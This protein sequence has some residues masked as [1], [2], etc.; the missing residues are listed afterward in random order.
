MEPKSPDDLRRSML[1]IRMVEQA[2]A[3]RYK[4]RFMRCPVH[5]S[6]GQEAVAVGVAAALRPNDRAFSSH[7]CHAH[8]LA[9]GGDLKAM[10]AELHGSPVGCNGGRGGSMHLQGGQL[11]ASLPIVGSA[12][13]PAV[14]MA[15]A[16]RMDGVDRVTVAFF[17]DAALEEGAWHEAA[18]LA[19][20]KSAPVLFVCENNDRSIY[21][22][23]ADRQPARDRGNLA[24]AHGMAW[25]EVNGTN[26][27]AVFAKASMAV[28]MAK[29]GPVLLFADCY[30]WAEHCG[31]AERPDPSSWITRDPLAR[32]EPAPA[33]VEQI[34]EE[35]AAAFAEVAH[36]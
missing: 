6:I 15:M 16:D 17:G 23:L 10:I 11:V 32:Y 20:V 2:I 36:A 21:T 33:V 9:L 25:M 24:R 30:R 3:D 13:P 8:Y 29:D 34:A 27:D 35:I 26:V 4:D 18:N 19:A 22:P 14:G 5:L 31:P 28:D 12:L 1:R 7:R